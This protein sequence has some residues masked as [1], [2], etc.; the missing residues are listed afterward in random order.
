MPPVSK[1]TPLPTNASGD[2]LDLFPFHSMVTRY[3]P[4]M[5]PCPTP[6]KALHPNFFNFF[7]LYTVIFNPYFFNLIN[8]FAYSSGCK[9]FPG[10]ETK[11]LVRNTPDFIAS[12]YLSSDFL[13]KASI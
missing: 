11:S 4:L 2:D 10:S 6:T 12:L 7:S 9:I 5:L 13:M 3:E 1:Q 8:L